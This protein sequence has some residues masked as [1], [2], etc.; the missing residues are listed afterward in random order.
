MRLSFLG[1]FLQQ[2]RVD[3]VLIELS[4]RAAVVYSLQ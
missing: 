1:W 3:Q 2:V 4:L